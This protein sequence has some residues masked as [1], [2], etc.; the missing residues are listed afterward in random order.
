MIGIDVIGLGI[1]ILSPVY[2]LLYKIS[3]DLKE[4]TTKISNCK[5]CTRR[6]E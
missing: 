6:E 2:G 5:Y 3:M 4:V 1:V